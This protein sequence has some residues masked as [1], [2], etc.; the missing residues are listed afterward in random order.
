MKKDIDWDPKPSE[1]TYYR[2]S[3]DGQRAYLVRK[4]GQDKLRLDRPMEE[5]LISLDGTWKPD[6]QSHPLTQHAVAAV[7][8][9]ADVVL[10]KS[11]GHMVKSNEMDWLSLGEQQRIK[12]MSRGPESGDVRDDLYDAIMGTLQGLTS[13]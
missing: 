7:A 12:W 9:A 5:I 8:F 1:R 10:R 4:N 6:V 11:M 3:Q 2:S 13:G